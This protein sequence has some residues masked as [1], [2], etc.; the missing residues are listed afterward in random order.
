MSRT[1][2]PQN[3]R[4]AQ[5]WYNCV[6]SSRWYNW[7][8]YGRWQDCDFFGKEFQEGK[9]CPEIGKA[10]SGPAVDCFHCSSCVERFL[11]RN[12]QGVIISTQRCVRPTI[13]AHQEDN[14]LIYKYEGHSSRFKSLLLH[15]YSILSFQ[16][17]KEKWLITFWCT[18]APLRPRGLLLLR[19][20]H[21]EERLR[22]SEA[23]PAPRTC[24]SFRK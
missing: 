21:H 19:V 4:G 9:T 20:P 18:A 7:S 14:T 5:P 6:D 16:M 1:R 24:S 22:S 23:S 8:V 15:F 3:L 12:L 11:L 10:N 13:T 17:R 2:P